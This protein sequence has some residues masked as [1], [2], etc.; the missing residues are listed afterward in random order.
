M[1]NNNSL[2]TEAE[3]KQIENKFKLRQIC[4]SKYVVNRLKRNKIVLMDI[5]NICEHLIMDYD[6]MIDDIHHKDRLNKDFYEEPNFDKIKEEYHPIITKRIGKFNRLS[7]SFNKQNKK[8][9]LAINRWLK[10]HALW[11]D[12]MDYGSFEDEI[13]DDNSAMNGDEKNGMDGY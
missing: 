13:K 10:E 11:S 12:Y 4:D 1:V 6:E 7:K 8:T 3:E 2:L 5:I 9:E